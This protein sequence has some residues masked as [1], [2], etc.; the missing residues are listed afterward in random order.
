MELSSGAFRNGARIPA[1]NCNFGVVGGQNLSIPLSWRGAPP[2]T[3]SFAILM[4]DRS[5]R[6]WIHWMVVDIGPDVTALP[7]GASGTDQ[8]PPRAHEMFTTFGEPGYGGPVPPPGTGDHKYET[9]VYALDSDGLDVAPHASV[10]EFGE[11]VAD[12][13]LESAPLVGYFGR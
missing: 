11:A 6:D 9:T 1:R 7:E 13:M 3:R 2:G 10:A 8:M 12:T 4:V 5:A